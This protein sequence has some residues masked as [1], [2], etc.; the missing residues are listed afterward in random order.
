MQR[1]ELVVLV[2]DYEALIRMD[3]VDT[4]TERGFSV[5]EAGSSAE[6]LQLLG[7]HAEIE[8]L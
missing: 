7:R 5:L 8:V 2:V 1:L 3:V 4:L 6:A